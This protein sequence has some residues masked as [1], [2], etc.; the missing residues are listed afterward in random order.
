MKKL[1]A[2]VFVAVLCLSS[3]QAT[4]EV[5][6]EWVVSLGGAGAT[7]TSGDTSTGFGADLSVG[8]TGKVLLPVEI[9]IRQGITY[10]GD[11]TL[12]STRVYADWTLFTV[13]TVDVFAGGAA[14]ITYGNTKPI[15]TIAP[16]AG[17]RWWVKNDVAV[18]GRVEVPFDMVEWE[19]NDV[20]R[21]F[22]G[23]QVKF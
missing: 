6:G 9:G 1:L 2:A 13:K 10:D 3:V 14:G 22:I 8:Y 12:L 4:D 11:D 18:I 20:L 16:E 17:L 23:F 5:G 7:V 15:W 21:Y 19:Y